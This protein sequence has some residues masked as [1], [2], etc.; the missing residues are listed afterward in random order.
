MP[1]AIHI[2]ALMLLRKEI[3]VLKAKNYGLLTSR[4]KYFLAKKIAQ[5]EDED[6]TRYWKTIVNK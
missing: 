2:R 6:F 3:L 1:E 5:K 4:T